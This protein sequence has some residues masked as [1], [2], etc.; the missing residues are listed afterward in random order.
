MS[1]VAALKTSLNDLLQRTTP[2]LQG[3]TTVPKLD[4]NEVE[5]RLQSSEEGK[6]RGAK[7]LPPLEST[8]NDEI[9]LKI[10]NTYQEMVDKTAADVNESLVTYNQRIMSVDLNG[11]IDNIRDEARSKISEFHAEVTK[12]ANDL[13]NEKEDVKE[14]LQDRK[15]FREDNYLRRSAS[16]PDTFGKIIRY[17]V[18]LLLFVFESIG[19]A[20]FLAKGN[21]GGIIGAYGESLAISFVNVGSAIIVGTWVTRGMFGRNVFLKLIS[22]ALVSSAILFSGVLNLVVAHY[23]ELSGAGLFGDAGAEAI[24]RILETPFGLTDLQGWLLFSVGWLFWVIAILDS[25]TM[26]DRFPS[27]GKVDRSL[28]KA[29]K[30]YAEIKA[31]II[32]DLSDK[33]IEGESEIKQIRSDLT[34]VYARVNE[35]INRRTALL[36]DYEMFTEQAKRFSSQ[37]LEKYRNANREERSAAPKSFNNKLE[38]SIPHFDVGDVTINL[39]SLAQQVDEGKVTLNKTLDSFFSEFEKA[40]FSFESLDSIEAGSKIELKVTESE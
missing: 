2:Y 32:E 12:G 15:I 20:V 35:I 10:Q 6:S 30:N 18:L 5:K 21:E 27:Y 34:E 3:S 29:R 37:S 14:K 38:I 25:H 11:M 16:Y 9:E 26:D 13:Q 19:N 23:R 40:I 8:I 39:D 24:Q 17:F 1:A 28:K 7:G 4:F 33:R 31:S 36:K 22:F